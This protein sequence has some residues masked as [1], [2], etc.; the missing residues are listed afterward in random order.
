MDWRKVG[1]Y[2]AVAAGTVAA[3]GAT[4]AAARVATDRQR[5]RRRSR[6]GDAME[7]GTLHVPAVTVPA[8][9]GVPLHVEVEE[10]DDLEAGDRP[11][12]VFCH[13][14]VLDL[15][16]WHYQRAA[17]RGQARMVLWD[18]REHGSSGDGSP[19]SCTL[20]QLGDDLKSVI[21]A[22]A[23]EGPLILVGHSMGAMTVMSF[24]AQYGDV[25]RDRV[26][27]VVL[28]GTSA[29]DLVR[30][31]DPLA[32]LHPWLPR[33]GPLVAA[34]RRLDSYPV[35]RAFAIGP[36]SSAKYADMTDEMIARSRDRALW[37]FAGNFVDL[38]LY[39]ALDVLPGRRTL[40]M[41]GTKDRLTPFRH[42]RRLAEMIDGSELIAYEG[43]GHMMMLERHEE[44]TAAIEG[45]WGS[46]EPAVRSG[47]G[48]PA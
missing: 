17:L 20:D 44:V 34:A 18:Q 8:T 6:R 42:S 24:A 32:L 41:G 33:L 11:T 25:V 23:P 15:D 7:F 31:K 47:E 29:G 19:E 9:D 26:V 13:G 4:A 27:G 14:W 40:V 1:A 12:I 39:D 28:M 35:T 48:W 45:L 30:P 10:P 43:A 3:A 46:A 38:D 22:V 16:C 36:T 5:V 37:D 2:A 21:D